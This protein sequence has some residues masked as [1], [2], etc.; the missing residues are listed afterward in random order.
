MKNEKGLFVWRLDQG[1]RPSSCCVLSSSR[2]SSVD[3][4]VRRLFLLETA[5]FSTGNVLALAVVGATVEVMGSAVFCVRVLPV[6]AAANDVLCVLLC[7][8]F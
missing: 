2:S 8:G 4:A 3:A 6:A 1:R 5:D 7:G